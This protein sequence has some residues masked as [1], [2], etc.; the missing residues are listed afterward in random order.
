[1]STAED[2]VGFGMKLMAGDLVETL[3]LL[4]ESQKTSSGEETGY[5]M[6]WRP[7]RDYRDRRVVHHGGSSEGARAFFLLYPDEGLAIALLANLANANILEGEA[8]SLA[9][10]FLPGETMGSPAPDGLEGRYR[11]SATA[12]GVEVEGE[13]SLTR[14]EGGYEGRLS[15]FYSDNAPV[16]HTSADGER[17]R[18]VVSTRSGLPSL[19]LRFD[20]DGFEGQWGWEKP[21]WP[22]NGTKIKN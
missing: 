13:L 4:F 8:E 21:R 5:G 6:G 9:Q 22:F 2:L 11:F 3:T 14:S 19:W 1:M 15:R 10:L 18:L 20:D 16:V 12:D 17:V 7:D